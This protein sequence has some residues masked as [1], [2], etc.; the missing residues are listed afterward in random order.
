MKDDEYIQEEDDSGKYSSTSDMLSSEMALSRLRHP[1]YRNKMKL[2]TL[3]QLYRMSKE[4]T[5][6]LKMELLYLH[7]QYQY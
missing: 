2:I 4:S 7:G 6:L 1:S 5:H 3:L